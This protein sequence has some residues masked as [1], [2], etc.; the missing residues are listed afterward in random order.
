MKS[1]T[2]A[3]AT[4]TKVSDAGNRDFIN[5]QNND[6]ADIYAC[7]DGGDHTALDNTTGWIIPASGGTLFISN[8]GGKN[9]WNKAVYLYSV[10][11]T[12]TK[13]VR[14]QGED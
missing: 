3:A 2:L 8:D 5:I 9:P 14:I 6:S 12:S 13:A 7:Y 4:V 1:V 11:G 10:A